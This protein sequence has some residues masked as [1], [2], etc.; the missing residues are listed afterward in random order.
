MNVVDIYF[1]VSQQNVL[2]DLLLFY[3]VTCIIRHT[4]ESFL[5]CSIQQNSAT[6]TISTSKHLFIAVELQNRNEIRNQWVLVV[7]TQGRGCYE[8]QRDFCLS[9]IYRFLETMTSGPND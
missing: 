8:S 6:E 9:G 5:L 3:T 2:T 7:E 4:L 1:H